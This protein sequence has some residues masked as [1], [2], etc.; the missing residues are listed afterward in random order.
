MKD[1]KNKNQVSLFDAITYEYIFVI[2]P[3]EV[4]ADVRIVRQKLHDPFG[5]SN[6]VLNSIPHISLYHF[7]SASDIDSILKKSLQALSG[8]KSFQVKLDGIK[9]FG[10]EQFDRTMYMEV[11]KCDA[12]HNLHSTLQTT[13]S[14]T[15]NKFDP[16]LTI[17]R[18]IYAGK[19]VQ[20]GPGLSELEYYG[21]FD[22]QQITLLRKRLG[23]EAPYERVR[24]INLEG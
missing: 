21:E 6:Q 14:K 19:Y 11:E 8:I 4:E 23:E 20:N 1:G 22:C 2:S 5:L 10:N 15:E 16:H 9:F 7:Y 24:I 13:F 3:K 12:L 18:E 17:A